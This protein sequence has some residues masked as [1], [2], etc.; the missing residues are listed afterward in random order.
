MKIVVLYETKKDRENLKSVIE[1]KGHDV[2]LVYNSNDFFEKVYNNDAERYVIDV[3][4][5]FRGS[6]IYNYFDIP[7]K[8]AATPITFINTPEGFSAIEGRDALPQDTFINKVTD[9]AEIAE[10]L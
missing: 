2:E 5:W 1:A 7:S 4:S 10:T 3:R 6:A 9:F 8:I